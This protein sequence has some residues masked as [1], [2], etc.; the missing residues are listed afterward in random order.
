VNTAGR[1]TTD[2]VDDLI[3]FLAPY[4]DPII[5]RINVE[6]FTTVEFVGVMQQDPP[7]AAAYEETVARWHEGDPQLAKMVVHG[8]VIPQ[9]LRRSPLVEWAGFAYGEQDA[10]AVPAWWRKG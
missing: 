3:A 7:T 4:I 2:N 5:E 1:P 8:Q 9:L 10:Y 6:E